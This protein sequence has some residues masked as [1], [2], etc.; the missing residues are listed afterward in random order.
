MWPLNNLGQ[1][2]GDFVDRAKNVAIAGA[3]AFF[4]GFVAVLLLAGAMAAMFAMWLPWPA[5]LA[6][7]A[8]A[9]LAIAAIVLW[10]G[11]RTSSLDDDDDAGEEGKG[12]GEDLDDIDIESTITAL[13]ELPVAAARKIVREQPIAALVACS[14]F[15]FLVARRPDVAARIL[16]RIV[17]RLT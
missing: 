11:V 4:L 8:V 7:S 5:A 12:K 15:G 10:V 16:E 6:I 17:T 1:L 13:T 2:A 3:I 14:T 9:F